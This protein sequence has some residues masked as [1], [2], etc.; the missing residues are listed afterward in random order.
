MAKTKSF[1]YDHTAAETTNMMTIY[2]TWKKGN[3]INRT[4]VQCS[5]YLNDLYVSQLYKKIKHVSLSIFTIVGE[6]YFS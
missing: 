3:K 1:L 4:K 6:V 5:K 2:E